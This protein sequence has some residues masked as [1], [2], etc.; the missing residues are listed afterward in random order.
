M[1]V[2]VFWFIQCQA[3]P[4]FEGTISRECKKPNG[5]IRIGLRESFESFEKGVSRDG[6]L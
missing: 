5:Q 2:H 1:K 6:I 4:K 3:A